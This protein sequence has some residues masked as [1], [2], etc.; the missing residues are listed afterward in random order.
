VGD[1]IGAT[2]EF[3]NKKLT[4]TDVNKAT[5]LNGGGVV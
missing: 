3:L 2:L 1:A 4:E 5:E